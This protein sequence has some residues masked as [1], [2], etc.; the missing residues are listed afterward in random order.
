MTDQGNLIFREVS[1]EE[2]PDSAILKC[3]EMKAALRMCVEQSGMELQDV[4]FRLNIE[5]GHL[6]RMLNAND[7]RH[8]PMDRL[9]DLMTICGN[10]IPLRWLALSRGYGLHRLKTKLEEENEHLRSE[11]E[12]MQRERGAIAGFFRDA[13]ID[14]KVSR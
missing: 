5:Y 6:K 13:G 12:A 8:F 7:D 9:N 10:E 2:I 11:L 3:K 4:A 1:R 14:V